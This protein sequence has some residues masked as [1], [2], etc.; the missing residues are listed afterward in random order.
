MRM[1]I[2]NVYVYGQRTSVSLHP[3]LANLLALKLGF[4]PN[5]TR[6]ARN[7]IC[8]FSQD[9]ADEDPGRYGMSYHIQRQAIL[10]IADPVLVY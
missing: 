4:D 3:E 1:K 5:D 10:A 7:A 9:C 8:A 6:A 2:Y